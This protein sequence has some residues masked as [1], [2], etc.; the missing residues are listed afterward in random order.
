M[1]MA[2][3]TGMDMATA[4]VTIRKMADGNASMSVRAVRC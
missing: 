2:M 1:D 3:V 4:M